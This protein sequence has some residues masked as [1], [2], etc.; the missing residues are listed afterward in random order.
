VEDFESH[1]RVAGRQGFPSVGQILDIKPAIIAASD[2]T[3]GTKT[4]AKIFEIH[5]TK[6][7]FSR[8]D[9]VGGV[10]KKRDEHVDSIKHWMHAHK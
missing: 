3:S 10:L 7:M 8:T 5:D 4:D 1:G 6:R 9:Q 2:A